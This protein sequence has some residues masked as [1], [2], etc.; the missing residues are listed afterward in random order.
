MQQMQSFKACLK[1]KKMR[2][3]LNLRLPNIIMETKNPK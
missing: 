3:T 2:S 1:P